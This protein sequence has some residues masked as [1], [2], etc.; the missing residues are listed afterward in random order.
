MDIV[1]QVDIEFIKLTLQNRVLKTRFMFNVFFIKLPSKTE[2]QKHVFDH[3][4]PICTL[5]HSTLSLSGTP[6]SQ[7]HSLTHSKLSKSLTLT[8]KSATLFS[9][10]P[11]ALFCFVYG[12]RSSSRLL[13]N[14]SPFL[15]CWIYVI[16][17]GFL[18]GGLHIVRNLNVRTY[19]DW[20]T[21]CCCCFCF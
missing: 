1:F 4:K 19:F 13:G 7:T 17:S 3:L 14:N 10:S 5:R 12:L 8:P 2:F 15:F 11:R 18:H 21:C 9:Q 20:R 16:D 6:P